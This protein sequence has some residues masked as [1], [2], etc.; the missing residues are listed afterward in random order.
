MA[1][2]ASVHGPQ[3]LRGL[4]GIAFLLLQVGTVIHARFVGSRWLGAWAPNDYAV[5]YRFQVS[6]GNRA[7]SS[8]EIAQRYALPAEGVYENPVLNITD[9]VRQREQT[10]GRADN[11][12]VV[13]RY[14]RNRGPMEEWRWPKN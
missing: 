12:Q 2:T 13:L 4:I 14:H 3:R 10:Y 7:L 8:A 11:A 9:I 1:S 5:W 6:V